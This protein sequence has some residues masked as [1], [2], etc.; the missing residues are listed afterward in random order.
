MST[1]INGT[2]DA[3]TFPD[4]TIQNTSAIVSG[5]VPYTNLPAGSVLQVITS[6]KTDTSSTSS[7]SLVDVSG[8]SLSITPKFSTSKIL[9]MA[10]VN[11]LSDGNAGGVFVGL[12]KNSTVLVASTAGGLAQT[13]QAF[14]CGG[15]GGLSN[16]NRKLNSAVINYLDSPATTSAT[17]YKIQLACGGGDTAYLNQWALN[18]DLASVSTITVMEIAQ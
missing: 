18:S 4:A 2:S 5:K 13:R 10:C 12:V 11:N 7:T 3:I 14:G 16:N 8:L 17:T 15:G 9:I 1:I 6:T